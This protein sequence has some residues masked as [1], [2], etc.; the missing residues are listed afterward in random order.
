MD[1]GNL[2]IKEWMTGFLI[3][4]L[5]RNPFQTGF[6]AVHVHRGNTAQY[7]RSIF[8]IKITSQK[9][10]LHMFTTQLLRGKCEAAPVL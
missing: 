3:H 7:I 9:S 4:C 6:C 8:I 1:A 5:E 2:R 10:M